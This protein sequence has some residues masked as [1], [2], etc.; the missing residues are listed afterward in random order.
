M[1]NHKA[2][3]SIFTGLRP[4]TVGFD[5]MFDHFDT[6]AHHLP[7]MTANNYP[8]YNIVKVSEEKYCIELAIAGFSKADIEIESKDNILTVSTL[9]KKDENEL[10][11]EYLH[12]GISAR[13]FK[14][15]FNL[16]EYVIVQG[17][18]FKDGILSIELERIVPEAMKPKT[19]KIK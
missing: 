12:K 10:E 4:F 14:K 1:T 3:Q 5:E 9:D 15:A 6:M 8:P 16:A 17:A 11:T 19:I 13:S 18:S 7:H 2:I